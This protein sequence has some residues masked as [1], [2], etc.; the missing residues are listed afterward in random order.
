M[1]PICS[2]QNTDTGPFLQLSDPD[3]FDF[4]PY[5][6]VYALAHFLKYVL[7]HN[8]VPQTEWLMQQIFIVS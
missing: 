3:L 1:Y 5:T 7:C 2:E 8:R 4:L 6:L